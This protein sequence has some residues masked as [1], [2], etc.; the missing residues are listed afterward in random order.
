MDTT[1]PITGSKYPSS[2]IKRSC[3]FFLSFILLII[4]FLGLI[5]FIIFVI[6]K[7]KKPLFTIQKTDIESYKLD[8]MLDHQSNNNNNQIF[9]SSLVSFT[10][11]A[12]NPNKFGISYTSSRLHVLEGQNGTVIGMIKIPRF[13][14]PPHSKNT[15]LP[16]Q[17]I[18]QCLNVNEIMAPTPTTLAD[19]KKKEDVSQ[20]MRILGDIGVRIRV[21]RINLPKL[22]IA[23]DCGIRMDRK[24]LSVGS[25]M[26]R[27][28]A[29]KEVS[30]SKYASLPQVSKLFS[31]KCSFALYL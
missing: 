11:N 6:V 3:L 10:L 2:L 22:R 14:Q 27:L 18:L 8:V 26:R 20:V 31:K 17:V 23:V 12:S 29:T 30:W 1:L 15:S 7:P 25:K 16:T 13:H 19:D 21:F 24:Q 9:L 5:S 28:K 4:L